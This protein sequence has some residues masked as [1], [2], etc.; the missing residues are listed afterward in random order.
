MRN[1]YILSVRDLAVEFHTDEGIVHAVNGVN[2]QIPRGKTFALVGESGCGKSVSTQAIMRLLPKTARIV[3]GEII[4]HRTN[5]SSVDLTK[6][7]AKDPELFKIR[8]KEIS[9]I[10]QEPMTSFSMVHTIGQQIT[11][12]IMLHETVTPDEARER[13][14]YLL[15]R[16]GIANPKQTV[17]MYP[18]SLSGGMR[19]RAM[20]ALALACNPSLV[21]A[22]EPTTAVDV[23][24]QAQILS[25][26]K[27]LQAEFGLSLLLITHN[28]GL[29]AQLA[30]YVAVM[31]MGKIVEQAPVQEIFSNPVHPYTKALLNSLPVLGQ[32]V[33]GKR[34]PSIKG[35]VPNPYEQILGCR[36]HTRCEEKIDGCQHNEP[37]PVE[38][39]PDHLVSCNL[40]QQKGE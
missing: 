34:L 1:D 31:Y 12:M 20:I 24:I 23:T 26:L 9:I 21:I 15:D 18:F 5:G 19:Q 4:F 3:S 27:E 29:V 17:D 2:F 25:L 32:K 14:I 28:F 37:V 38:V 8:G 33:K 39:G 13:V 11:E 36:F 16:V 30:N 10:F 22:D 7:N 40:L 6:L 35:T